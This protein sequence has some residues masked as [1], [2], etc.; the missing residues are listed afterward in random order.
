MY[1]FTKINLKNYELISSTYEDCDVVYDCLV[2]CIRNFCYINYNSDVD[3]DSDFKDPIY[4]IDNNAYI[5]VKTKDNEEIYILIKD[6]IVVRGFL[7]NTYNYIPIYIFHVKHIY[8][9]GSVTTLD[10]VTT[11]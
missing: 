8:H 5:H 6:K 2:D 1:V 9:D 11:T 3:I 4:Q 10:Y 7:F